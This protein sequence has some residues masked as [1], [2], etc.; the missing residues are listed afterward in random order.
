LI[1]RV[2]LIP[3]W[4]S[5]SMNTTVVWQNIIYACR[6]SQTHIGRKISTCKGRHVACCDDRSWRLHD[7]VLWILS[8]G[9]CHIDFVYWNSVKIMKRD[10]NVVDG[11]VW[12]VIEYVL[13]FDLHLLLWIAVKM[14][15]R[16]YISSYKHCLQKVFLHR[17][18]NWQR[19]GLG[20]GRKMSLYN[21]LM[22][23]TL[24]FISN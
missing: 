2:T 17:A 9:C 16:P 12:D 19:R 21:L 20:S 13:I 6:L 11:F 15:A 23:Q 10:I 14:G 8:K 5:F 7:H 4:C 22:C 1:F 24:E 3:I 18:T